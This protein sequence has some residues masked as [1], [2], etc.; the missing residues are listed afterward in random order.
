[1]LYFIKIHFV[2]VSLG[3]TCSRRELPHY[4]GKLHLKFL[5]AEGLTSETPEKF[6]PFRL[7]VV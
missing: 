2:V 6:S 1:M 7:G 5:T 3:E 4:V